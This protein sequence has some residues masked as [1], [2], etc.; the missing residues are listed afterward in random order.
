M[1]KSHRAACA[2][3]RPDYDPARYTDCM[4][5]LIARVD[6]ARFQQSRPRML[7][8]FI[9]PQ[10]VIHAAEN[11][12]KDALREAQ[13]LLTCEPEYRPDCVRDRDLIDSRLEWV[14][15]CEKVLGKSQ[16][17]LQTL[18]LFQKKLETMPILVGSAGAF[19]GQSKKPSQAPAAALEV[20][21][22]VVWE[23]EPCARCRASRLPCGGK[24]GRACA[25]CKRQ[26]VSCNFSSARPAKPRVPRSVV[27]DGSPRPSSSS[28]TPAVSDIAT[29]S[30]SSASTT[31]AT[32]IADSSSNHSPSISP[33]LKRK[34]SVDLSRTVTPAP[35]RSAQVRHVIA[36]RSLPAI[37]ED[38]LRHPPHIK[39][40]VLDRRWKRKRKQLSLLRPLQIGEQEL[41]G[42]RRPCVQCMQEEQDAL[43]QRCGVFEA[44]CA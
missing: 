30:T 42:H 37:R 26:K 10:D 20:G 13:A 9:S 12:Y 2:A 41:R 24:H 6:G 19:V 17:A 14:D 39:C 35:K 38:F 36:V 32:S 43:Q 33:T 40:D 21:D 27:L 16:A 22:T 7:A 3:S 29:S 8:A 25:A 5:Q 11:T 18:N 28:S 23:S 34:R 44:R 1:S 4:A 15:E 31:P